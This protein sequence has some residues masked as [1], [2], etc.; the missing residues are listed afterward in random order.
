MS[1]I[2]ACLHHGDNALA[3]YSAS[4]LSRIC[5]LHFD[6]TVVK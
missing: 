4:F 1:L 2:F 3:I 6:R 5:N